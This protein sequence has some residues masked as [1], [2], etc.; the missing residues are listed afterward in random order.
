MDSSKIKTKFKNI[1]YLTRYTIELATL[2]LM[3]FMR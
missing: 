1:G 3:Q 2:E